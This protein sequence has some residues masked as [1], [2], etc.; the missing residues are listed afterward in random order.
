MRLRPIIALLALTA[1]PAIARADG[2][3][4]NRSIDWTVDVGGSTGHGTER[5]QR[6]L[7]RWET[8]PEDEASTFSFHYGLAWRPKQNYSFKAT[9]GYAYRTF[10][11]GDAGHEA[12][13][14]LRKDMLWRHD[15]LWLRMEGANY[16]GT[17][18]YRYRGFYALDWWFVGAHVAQENMNTYIGFHLT[19]GPRLEIPMHIEVQHS[20]GLQDGAR[21]HTVRLLLTF[22]TD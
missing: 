4:E 21:D 7:F 2:K 10:P 18:G 22:D 14:M 15:T 12:V 9:L 17:D 19:S 5:G 6:F 13:L 11:A 16:L 20:W 8:D 3:E 1:A